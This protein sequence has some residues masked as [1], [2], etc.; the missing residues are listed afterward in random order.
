MLL[1]YTNDDVLSFQENKINRDTLCQFLQHSC[2]FL[3]KTN[4]KGRHIVD[5][6]LSMVII[7][8]NNVINQRVNPGTKANAVVGH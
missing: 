2:T 3:L 1:S 8:Y 4:R 7:T 6:Y 5:Q